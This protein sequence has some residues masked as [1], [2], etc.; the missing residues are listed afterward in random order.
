[1]FNCRFLY[2]I[3][4]AVLQA[5]RLRTSRRQGIAEIIAVSETYLKARGIKVVVLDFDG[6]LAAHGAL[7][8]LP[9]VVSWLQA[10][11]QWPNFEWVIFSNKPTSARA[12]YF[13]AN[14]PKIHFISGVR[15]KPYPDGLHVVLEKF[16]VQAKEILMVDDRLLTGI[17]AG[18]LADTSTLLI[19]HPYKRV[20]FNP[21]V[22]IFFMVLRG[23]EKLI[24]I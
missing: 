1:M 11:M 9:K 8:P 23:V 3:V 10:A 19:T 22:E 12:R 14:F 24:F 13:Q 15:K 16:P 6:V 20:L 4:Q 5:S 21:L 2:S 18:I 7:V 17:L